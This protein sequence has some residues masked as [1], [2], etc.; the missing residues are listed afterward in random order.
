MKCKNNIRSS[1]IAWSTGMTYIEGP[2]D[3]T[4]IFTCEFRYT[5]YDVIDALITLI[6]LVISDIWTS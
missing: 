3:N 4:G 6:N 5:T 2:I 1:A